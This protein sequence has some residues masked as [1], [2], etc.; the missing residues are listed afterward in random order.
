MKKILLIS[1]II[2][3][4]CFAGPA[5]AK[6]RSIYKVRAGTPP[7]EIIRD[8][9]SA[10]NQA[11]KKGIDLK[12]SDYAPYLTWLT[13]PDPRI[14]PALILNKENEIYTVRN[15]G[16]QLELAAGAIDYGVRHLLTPVLLITV[17]S[18][19]QAVRFFMNGYE[20][21]PPSIRQ[22]LDHLYLALAYDNKKAPFK[23]RLKKNIESNV[24]Y[25][26]A[27]ALSR[28]HDRVKSGRLVVV[29]S[30]LDFDNI[31]KHG[32]GRLVII[33]INGER[34]SDKLRRL[35]ML[36]FVGPKFI[37]LCV[38]R[39]LEVRLVHPNDQGKEDSPSPAG[40]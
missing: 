38:G 30:V 32:S 31:Y 9:L 18:D 7:Y 37:N 23:V 15:F 14:T 35:P 28:Y 19:N 21:L 25:Q 24:D 26:V 10:N 12:K 5:S 29:G 16:G 4:S 20:D 36:K 2:G 1:L 33:N 40:K 22:D 8:V 39:R 13:D 27:L 17:N 3:Y 11:L 34:D 6:M